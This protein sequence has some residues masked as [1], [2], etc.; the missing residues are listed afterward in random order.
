MRRFLLILPALLVLLTPWPASADTGAQASLTLL[1]QSPWNG[2]TTPLDLRLRV[3]N[4]GDVPLSD[5]SFSIT[6]ETPTISRGEYADAMRSTAPRTAVVSFPFPEPETTIAPG[7]SHAFR[8]QQSLT[9]LST[10]ALYPIRVDLLSSLQP[11]ATLRTPMIF[12]TEQPK[13]PLAL[14]TT[15]VLWEPLQLRPDGSLGPGPIESD[16]APGGRLDRTVKAIAAGPAHVAVAVSPVLIDELR[17][18]EGGYR[19]VDGQHERT[20]PKGQGSSADA[21]RMIDDLAQ[22]AGRKGTQV[23]AMPFG[24]PSLPSLPRAGLGLQTGVL[25]QRGQRDLVDVLG[26]QPSAHLLRPP[27]SQIDPASAARAARAGARTLLLDG[28][29]IPPPTGLKFSPPPTAP[30]VAGTRT[31]DAIVPDPTLAADIQTWIGAPTRDTPELSP[32]AARYALGELATIYLETP[33]TPHRGAAVLFPERTGAGPGFLHDFGELIGESPWLQPMNPTDLVRSLPTNRAPVRLAPQ[34]G[35]SFPP[36]YAGAFGAARDALVRFRSTVQGAGDLADRL[37]DDLLLSLSGA[38]VRNI[39]LGQDFL[40]YVN[41]TVH[42]V[43]KDIQPPATGHMVTIPS[44]RGT[45]VFTV[46]NGTRYQTRILVKLV[47]HGQLTLPK[48][49]QIAVVLQ[50]G[51]TTLV[52]MAVQAQ[53]TGRFPITVQILAPQGGLIAQSQLIVRST[54][55]NRLA[56]FVT[57]G[58]VVFL[59][60]WWGRRFLPRASSRPDEPAPEAAPQDA[61]PRETP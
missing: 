45:V 44:L 5:L 13:L 37:S 36:G 33:G 19:S 53:T 16:I 57:A 59:L 49:D 47:P 46:K 43:L 29:K 15:W 14:A 35:P 60:L 7:A 56:L 8:F 51:E 17:V 18:M 1:Q 6:I 41:G 22:V 24:D 31:V 54:A 2:P 61:A 4:T 30:V 20:V 52:Q 55:Y 3:T 27:L 38:A 28:G 39:P 32:L 10:T 21:A 34:T 50:P 25:M 48:G 26:V 12:L 42:H 11:V 58:A 9:A 23:V 40:S